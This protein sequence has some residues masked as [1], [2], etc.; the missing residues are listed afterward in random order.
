ME[1]DPKEEESDDGTEYEMM[2]QSDHVPSYRDVKAITLEILDMVN[3]NLHVTAVINSLDSDVEKWSDDILIHLS[4]IGYVM[5]SHDSL[6]AV[7]KYRFLYTLAFKP[8][9]LRHLWNYVTSVSTPSVFGS[10]TSLLQ[11][12]SRGL[13]IAAVEWDHILPQLTLFCSLLGYL[14]PTV[15]DVQFY[16]AD[17]GTDF[18]SKMD[19][20]TK[21]S[22]KSIEEQ[23]KDKFSKM[24]FTIPGN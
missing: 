11:V 23:E 3:D 14:L 4:C 17:S 8:L 24:P 10:P 19:T 1:N 20:D 9:F 5:L 13:P 18:E 2:D 22:T 7:N 16:G 21:L 15:D 12:L 6:V